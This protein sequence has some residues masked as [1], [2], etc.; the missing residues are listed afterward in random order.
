MSFTPFILWPYTDNPVNDI[1]WPKLWVQQQYY[2]TIVDNKN[3]LHKNKQT[4]KR[5]K[6][7]QFP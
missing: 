6:L 5:I 2:L 4:Y 1:P 7:D 3:S